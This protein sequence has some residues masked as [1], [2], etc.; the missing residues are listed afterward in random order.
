MQSILK[1]S[2]FLILII[3]WSCTSQ[4]ELVEPAETTPPRPAGTYF[5]AV[6]P[7]INIRTKNSTD[8]A[9]SGKLNDGD[10]VLVIENQNG[11]YCVQRD[12]NS[13]GWIRSDLL[14]PKKVSVFA[15]AV[16]FVD[17]LLDNDGTELFFDKKL[18]HRRIYLAYPASM[19][20]SKS[21]I[22]KYTEKLVQEYQGEVYR[23]D[24]TARVLKPGS[25]DEYLTIKLK[26]KQNPDIKL[27]VLPFG[28]L[29]DVDNTA[30]ANIKLTIT[31]PDSVSN[32]DIIK[33]ARDIVSIYPISYSKVEL[34]FVSDQA[35][36]RLWYSED[37]NGEAYKLNECPD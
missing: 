26:G 13:M 5:W 31:T 37:E 36:C 29:S 2:F 27:P 3:A 33:T 21:K 19:Y 4:K 30:P 18:L 16:N 12:D 9:K 8:S 14:G 17:S 1:Y 11:W 25:Q 20:T 28:I 10:S 23:G 15:N 24:V 34:L 22:E 6:K 32:N 35:R 7:E